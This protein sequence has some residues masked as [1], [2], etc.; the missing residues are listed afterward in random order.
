MKSNVI[1]KKKR[2]FVNGSAWPAVFFSL[3]VCVGM[4]GCAAKSGEH[5]AALEQ[6]LGQRNEEIRELQSSVKQLEGELRAKDKE[7]Q[8]S[9]AKERAVEI[10]ASGTEA[11]LLPQNARPGYCYAKVFVP[12]KYEQESVTVLSR[13]ASERIEVIP[14]KFEM[15]E[16]RVL[17]KDASARLEIIPA[18][19]ETVEERVLVKPASTKL[20]EEPA[21]YQW[22]EEKILVKP[23][24]TVWKKGRGLV[25][26]V[27]DATGEI[28]CLVE[29]PA[30]FKTVKKRIVEEP[31]IT[32]QVEI[33]A[34]YKTI[35][36]TVMVK[37]PT[38]RSVEIPAVYETVKVRQMVSAAQEKRIEIPASYETVTKTV[39]ASDGRLE[40][41][42]ALCETNMTSEFITELQQALLRAGHDPGNIDG[43]Y[44]QRTSAAVRSYQEAKGLPRGVLTLGTLQSLGLR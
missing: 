26:R 9:A 7:L 12:P 30:V 24:Q 4:T 28:M 40:W 2:F 11:A 32:R 1:V 13:E 18:Q 21:K 44:G 27:D 41:R 37:P 16:K 31:A 3:A 33:P 39:K 36:K 35:K 25:E 17:V 29:E 34:E 22:V 42:P 23:A 43:I 20:V 8:A 19:Y 5:V 6:E 15:V 38:T 10:P 14:A